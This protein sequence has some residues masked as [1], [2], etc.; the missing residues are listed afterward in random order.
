MQLVKIFT[1]F[2]TEQKAKKAFKV[3]RDKQGVICKK[4]SCTE[5]YWKR[6]KEQYE[7]K[8]CRFR[9]TLRSGTL[10]ESSNTNY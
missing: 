1:K 2:S 3:H 10:L 8:N 4:C 9:T 6:D 5:H 7:C